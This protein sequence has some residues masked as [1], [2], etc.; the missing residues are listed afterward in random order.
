MKS[1][2]SIDL[3]RDPP[4]VLFSPFAIKMISITIITIKS[5]FYLTSFSFDI[6]SIYIEDPTT[7][8]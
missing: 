6:Y 4:P 8:L 1:I 5:K 2:F 7:F 3:V